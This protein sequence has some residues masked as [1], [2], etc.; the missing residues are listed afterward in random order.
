MGQR[1]CPIR[2]AMAAAFEIRLHQQASFLEKL[3][4][5]VG[6]RSTNK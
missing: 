6:K 4:Q 3:H 5:L 1:V 2:N